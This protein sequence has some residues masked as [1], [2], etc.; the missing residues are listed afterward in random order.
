MGFV[1]NATNG[2]DA[3]TLLPLNLFVRMDITGKNSSGWNVTGWFYDGK[4]YPTTE[5]LRALVSSPEFSPPLANIDGNWTSTDPQGE[6]LEFDE[7]PPP[8]QVSQGKRRFSL[9]E[10]EKYVEWMGFS[11]YSTLSKDTGLSLFDVQFKGERIIYELG[12]Q[13]ALTHYAGAD[14]VVS[15]TTFLDTQAGFGA[16]VVPLINGHDCPSYATYLNVS[17]DYLGATILDQA[18]SI[19]IFERETD[20]PL[21]RHTAHD[22]GSPP[23]YRYMSVTKNVQLIVRSAFSVGNYDFVLS[24]IFSLDGTIEVS[25]RASG[26]IQSAYFKGNEEYGFKIHDALSG[27]MHDHVLTFKADFDILGTKNSVQK[28]EFVPATV[29]YVF[30]AFLIASFSRK[31]N[32]TR[33]PWAKGKP[34]NTMKVQKSFIKN[35]ADSSLTW[36]PNDA[37]LYAIVNKDTPNRFGE[38]RGYRIKSGNY[39]PPHILLQ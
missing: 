10:K 18:N 20:Y 1:N 30:I 12:L 28:V 35:E 36:A 38:Y 23:W 5:E 21:R 15:G 3:Y 17:W 19:C 9:D 34:R 27:S 16:Q 8:K 39:H 24:Y 2:F 11:F 29:E 25:V 33:Y 32:H 7:L 31:T 14:P 22:G 4:F 13:E 6:P 37:A 26:Y